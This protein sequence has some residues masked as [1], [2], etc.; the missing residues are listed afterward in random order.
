MDKNIIQLEIETAHL[1]RLQGNFGRGRQHLIDA[2]TDAME[3]PGLEELVHTV[4][5]SLAESHVKEAQRLDA[6]GLF[7][8]SLEKLAQAKNAYTEFKDSMPPS[9]FDTAMRNIADQIIT[10]NGYTPEQ[11]GVVLHNHAASFHTRANESANNKAYKE[12]LNLWT[13]AADRYLN[14]IH[15]VKN[16]DRRSDML[17]DYE[18]KAGKAVNEI[19][20]AEQSFADG[21]FSQGNYQCSQGNLNQAFGFWDAAT[22]AYLSII[23]TARKAKALSIDLSKDYLEP[24]LKSFNTI[25]NESIQWALQIKN[26]SF[27]EP[28]LNKLRLLPPE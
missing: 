27:T 23:L 9:D 7:N 8:E 2:K 4:N 21:F 20:A 16:A 19:L 14:L 3:T 18:S 10:I 13:Q 6:S 15:V 24:S 1:Y 17:K 26:P 11:K 12:A 28:Y 25:L 22:D 5:I